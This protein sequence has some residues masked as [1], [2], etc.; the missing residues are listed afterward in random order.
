MS[1][2][3][4]TP[5]LVVGT[6]AQ[7]KYIMESFAVADVGQCLQVL[8]PDGEHSPGEFLGC[9]LIGD[10]GA[11]PDPQGYAGAIVG[12]R[13]TER[14]RALSERL[15]RSGFTLVRAV[16]PGAS[17]ATSA[18]LGDG[19]IVNAGAVIQPYA[20]IGQGVMVHANAVV[21]HDAHVAGFA[22]IGPGAA[23][24][25]WVEIGEHAVIFTGAAV[26]PG[27][28]VGAGATVAAGAVV[29]DDVAAG[30]T[31]AGVPATTI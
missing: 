7:A 25:G 13:E 22:N 14:K 28:A 21:E 11:L 5:I 16:H 1:S 29:R 27:V 6:G 20:R 17:I 15:V 30:A 9:R 18:Q 8:D 10:L 24:T 3:A 23:L 19:C 31:V 26:L 12:V 2:D 4:G